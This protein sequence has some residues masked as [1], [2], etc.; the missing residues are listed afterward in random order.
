MIWSRKANGRIAIDILMEL[1]ISKSY[2]QNYNIVHSKPL[3]F[4]KFKEMEIVRD[5]N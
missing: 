2:Y 4:W 1:V 5:F 3:V